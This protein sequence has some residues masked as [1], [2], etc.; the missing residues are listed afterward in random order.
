M[1]YFKQ[2]LKD[3]PHVAISVPAVLCFITFITNFINSL[4]DGVIDSNEMHALL[5]TADG[6]ES[7]FLFIVVI[8]LKRKNK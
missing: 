2:I 7:V 3:Y 8:V 5:A 6:F 4:K 1:D